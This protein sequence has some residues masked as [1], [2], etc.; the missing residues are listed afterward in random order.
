E[1]PAVPVGGGAQADHARLAPGTRDELFDAVEFYFNRTVH[2]PGQ[3]RGDDVDRVDVQAAAEVPA[4]GGLQHPHTLT[5][6]SER[7]AKVTLVEERHLG[8]RPHRE[9]SG[10]VPVGD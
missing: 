9:I 8:R 2:A 10:E 5:A 1:E 6:D 4:D 7:L 3:Q